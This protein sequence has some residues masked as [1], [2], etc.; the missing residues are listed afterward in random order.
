MFVVF[1]F[2]YMFLLA[3]IGKICSVV[4][5]LAAWLFYIPPKT[6][7]GPVQDKKT[8]INE[9]ISNQEDEKF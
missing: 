8:S 7:P 2:R 9:V 6:A 3:F 1:S 4:F 5:Y